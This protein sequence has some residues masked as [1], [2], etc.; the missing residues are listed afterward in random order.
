MCMCVCEAWRERHVMG[1]SLVFP[2]SFY[3]FHLAFTLHLFFTFFIP[4]HLTFD[5]I[6]LQ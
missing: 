6:A 4:L 1:L 5:F 2:S 3:F